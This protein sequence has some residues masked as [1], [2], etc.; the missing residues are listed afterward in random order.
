M[1]LTMYKRVLFAAVSMS[2][3]VA[4]CGEPAKTVDA[5]ETAVDRSAAERANLAYTSNVVRCE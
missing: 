3:L 2:A 4:F 5:W 1:H